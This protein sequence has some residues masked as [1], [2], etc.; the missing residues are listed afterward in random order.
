MDYS[1]SIKG[2]H[3]E[4]TVCHEDILSAARDAASLL[5][6][7]E[8]EVLL[9]L[10]PLPPLRSSAECIHTPAPVKMVEPSS[11]DTTTHGIAFGVV[12]L[13]RTYFSVFLERAERHWHTWQH[14]QEA[15]Q[16]ARVRSCLMVC[17][18]IEAICSA[19]ALE[20]VRSHLLT[21]S[22]VPSEIMAPTFEVALHEL[23]SLQA[24]FCA[25]YERLAFSLFLC[26]LTFACLAVPLEQAAL[27]RL[28]D[29]LTPIEQQCSAQLR[30]LK[31]EE[32]V[33]DGEE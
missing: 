25:P 23:E 12:G 19:E 5:E 18:A 10:P 22:G 8:H 7:A 30:S 33:E 16:E 2:S 28:R 27:D 11:E 20:Q 21:T 14:H 24:I 6:V 29:A 17:G 26:V 13:A 32:E 4:T 3:R 15:D 9:W 31:A 1:F